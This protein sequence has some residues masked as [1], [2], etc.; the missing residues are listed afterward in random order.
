[1]Q[2]GS[3][4]GL[5]GYVT[6]SGGSYTGFI[7]DNPNTPTAEPEALASCMVLNSNYS[8]FPGGALF[9]VQVTAAHE[10]VH[11][12]QFGLGDP[13]TEEDLMFYESM[14]SYG[15]D[16]VYDAANDNYQYLPPAYSSCLGEYSGSEYSNWLFFRYAAESNGGANLAGGGENVIQAFWQ[17]VAA[18]YGALDAF[19]N[20][21]AVKGSNL[22][23]TFHKYAITVRFMSSCPAGANTALKAAGYEGRLVTS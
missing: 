3:S 4:G 18:G 16:E 15:E 5:Y 22:A 23:D 6:S 13:G 21:L 17:N 7:G 10:F 1:V 12:I 20:G 14:A 19:N 11:A 2:I 8:G 9:S